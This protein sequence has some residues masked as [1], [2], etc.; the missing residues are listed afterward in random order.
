MSLSV[1]YGLN[2][3]SESDKF[4]SVSEE[5]T[6][7]VDTALSPGAFLVDFFPSRMSPSLEGP[8]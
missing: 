8:F 5:A 6:N 2:V 7:A 4:Y 3:E 1:A